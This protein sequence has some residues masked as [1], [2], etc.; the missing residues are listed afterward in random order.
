[1]PRPKN[2]NSCAAEDCNKE[3]YA[4]GYCRQHWHRLKTYGRLNKI[5]GIIKGICI[6]EGCENKIKGHGFCVNHLALKRNYGIDPKEYYEK[7]KAQNYRC[8]ICGEEETSVAWNTNNKVKKLA[9][10]HDHKTGKIRGLLCVR[11]N[12]FL[13]RINENLDLLDKMKAYLIRHL[14]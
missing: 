5:K 12:T 8:D 10:D 11:C 2:L 14:T 6:I 3:V 1:M 9:M 13:G 7:L 4:K